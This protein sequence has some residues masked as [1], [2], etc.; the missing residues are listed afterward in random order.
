MTITCITALA[1]VDDY[2]VR[3][4]VF[5]TC[6]WQGVAAADP[7]SYLKD[8][9]NRVDIQRDTEAGNTPVWYGEFSLATQFNATDDFLCK[10]ADAQKLMYSQNAGW[11]FWNFKTECTSSY[12]R[13]WS[14]FEGLKRGYLTKDPSQLNDPDVCVPYRNISSNSTASRRDDTVSTNHLRSVWSRKFSKPIRIH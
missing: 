4:N 3:L 7:E 6:L 12:A 11:L 14:Y 1:Y 8:L 10:W 5:S 13:Q 9:C 2:T